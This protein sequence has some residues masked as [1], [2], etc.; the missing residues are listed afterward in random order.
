MAAMMMM[1]VL[2]VVIVIIIIIIIIIRARRRPA[3]P[4]AAGPPRSP[5]R[6][7]AS[8]ANGRQAGLI[9]PS[10]T[11]NQLA[12]TAAAAA[13]LQAKR[14]LQLAPRRSAASC[15]HFESR[16]FESFQGSFQAARPLATSWPK[17]RQRRSNDYPTQSIYEPRKR[18]RLPDGRQSSP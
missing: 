7:L 2:V 8:F 12:M 5:V 11:F 6:S 15:S 17:T 4:A 3:R 18:V 10:A 9:W 1:A 16:A 14:P 13:P